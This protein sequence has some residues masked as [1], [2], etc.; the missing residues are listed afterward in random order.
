MNVNKIMVDKN[1]NKK[2]DKAFERQFE[3][4]TNNNVYLMGRPDITSKQDMKKVELN[5]YVM[6]QNV[7]LGYN[8]MMDK[9]QP[10]E[11]VGS[12]IDSIH[13]RTFASIDTIIPPNIYHNFAT[14]T[15]E[16]KKEINYN[17]T[18]RNS[19]RIEKKYY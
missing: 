12:N 14:S 2:A 4:I 19:V 8:N 9:N 13:S 3:L 7:A 18:D 6:Q 15:R 5:K 17:I 10:K 16:H 11:P 1:D